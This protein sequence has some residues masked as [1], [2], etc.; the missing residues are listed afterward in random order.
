MTIRVNALG[1]LLERAGAI[2]IST[3]FQAG[4][5][6]A[7]SP[8]MRVDLA[9]TSVRPADDDECEEEAVHGGR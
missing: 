2:V 7:R 5:R 4:A 8:Q 3:T 1:E 6:A 9:A